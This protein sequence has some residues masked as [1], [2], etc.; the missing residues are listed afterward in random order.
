[1]GKAIEFENPKY[2]SE[3]HKATGQLLDYSRDFSYT[4]KKETVLTTMFD[5]NTS[6]TIEY[7]NLLIS[8]TYFEKDRT[9]EYVGGLDE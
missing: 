2:P 6:K 7:Y 3:N 8:C 5:I 4:R 9:I 1:M